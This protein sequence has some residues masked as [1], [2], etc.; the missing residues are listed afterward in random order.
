MRD[1]CRSQRDVVAAARAERAGSTRVRLSGRCEQ[2]SAVD[3]PRRPYLGACATWA[4]RSCLGFFLVCGCTCAS[5]T[6]QCGFWY[7]LHHPILLCVVRPSPSGDGSPLAE[8]SR[9][10]RVRPPTVYGVGR[11]SQNYAYR[12]A[13]TYW[14]RCF[15]AGFKTRG[16]S[17]I[18]SG[19]M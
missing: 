3:H 1:L 8:L 18:E 5:E 12:D 16:C 15:C 9:F 19:D 14:I 2:S 10:L 7:R 4:F 17:L 6:R 11:A 13:N